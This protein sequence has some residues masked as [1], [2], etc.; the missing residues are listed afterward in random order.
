VFAEKIKELLILFAI[1]FEKLVNY[2]VE[3]FGIVVIV[4]ICLFVVIFIFSSFFFFIGRTARV[5]LR[6]KLKPLAEMLHA[7]IKSNFMGGT[8]INILNYKPEIRF[9]I[10]LKR[11]KHYSDLLIEMLAPIGLDLTIIRKLDLDQLISIVNEEIKM[12][13]DF[14]KEEYLVYSDKPSGAR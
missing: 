10:L 11:K 9:R 8:Y 7:E 14:Y 13:D 3:N 5:I 4:V 12:N 2:I 1:N 6:R